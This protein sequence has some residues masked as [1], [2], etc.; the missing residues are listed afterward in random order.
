MK[1]IVY[2]AALALGLIFASSC[3]KRYYITEEYY[4]SDL[5]IK[6]VEFT[7]SLN[8]WEYSDDDNNNYYVASVNMPEITKDV[9]R[10]GVVKMYRCYD[11]NT[12]KAAMAEMPFTRHYEYE[13]EGEWF[14][15][16]ETIDYEASEGKIEI[17]Y[18]LNDFAYELDGEIVPDSPMTFKCSIIY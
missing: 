14:F 15:Y 7:V 11:W 4:G 3:T 6:N 16:T 1:K 8:Q 10:K 17:F 5:Q 9:L 18:T 2:F 12:P 13:S